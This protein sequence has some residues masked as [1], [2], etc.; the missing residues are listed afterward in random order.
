MVNSLDIAAVSHFGLN[1]DSTM[2]LRR[3]ASFLFSRALRRGKLL[4]F[5]CKLTGK[6]NQLKDLT[7]LFQE[8][9]RHWSSK[10]DVINVALENIVGSEGRTRDFDRAFNP[11][12]AH[13]SDRWIGIAVA[14]RQGTVLPPVELIQ[15]GDEYYV[16][17]GHHRISV[18]KA[19]G[20]EEIEAK[21]LYVQA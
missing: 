9:K 15:V 8:S 16:R 7:H 5:W 2:E 10:V 3:K 17:D 12:N 11:L 4:A 18:A 21:I 20:Q 19:A 13:N 14:R 6:D 1:D